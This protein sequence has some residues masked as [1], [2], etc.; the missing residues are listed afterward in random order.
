M[1]GRMQGVA[2]VADHHASVAQGLLDG[3]DTGG[4]LDVDGILMPCMPRCC[5]ARDDDALVLGRGIQRH[6]RGVMLVKFFRVRSCRTNADGG[7]DK[8]PRNH[9]A[10]Y[11]HTQMCVIAYVDTMLLRIVLPFQYTCR[12]K[13]Q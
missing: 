9:T 3:C 6:W 7:F 1:C 10:I 4:T 11:R 12:K 13:T 5:I 8:I 2:S